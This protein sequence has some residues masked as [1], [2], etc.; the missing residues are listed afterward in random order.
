[1][2][3]LILILGLCPCVLINEEVIVLYHLI[4]PKEQN[5]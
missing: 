5:K 3:S 1:M 2:P 4:Q